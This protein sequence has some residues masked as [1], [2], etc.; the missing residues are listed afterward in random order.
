MPSMTTSPR[1]ASGLAAWCASSPWSLCLPL[2]VNRAFRAK[3]RGKR[4]LG[5]P[6]WQAGFCLTYVYTDRQGTPNGQRSKA[7][8]RAFACPRSTARASP[9]AS[10]SRRSTLRA[11]GSAALR[12]C[13]G[14]RWWQPFSL[15]ATRLAATPARYET[16]RSGFT[17][18]HLTQRY[19]IT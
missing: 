3:H 12:Q 16:R 13:S 1:S 15:A 4:R 8:R 17:V 5:G 10:C 9:A 18:S 14:W 19:E 11:I 6:A 7:I 2:W